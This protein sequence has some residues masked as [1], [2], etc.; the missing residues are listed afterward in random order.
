LKIDNFDKAQQLADQLPRYK[1]R[2]F[3]DV[4]VKSL[5]QV[6]REY[7]FG[8]SRNFWKLAQLRGWRFDRFLAWTPSN[9]SNRTCAKDESAWI[10]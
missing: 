2:R 10:A 7:W 4:A 9:N 6:P 3:L 1:W 5:T 8:R